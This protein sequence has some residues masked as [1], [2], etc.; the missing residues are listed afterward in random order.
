MG[1]PD[2]FYKDAQG[3]TR[4]RFNKKGG[5]AVAATALAGTVAFGASGI[6]GAGAGG[7]T[8]A[9][10]VAGQ[11]LHTKTESGKSEAR[12]GRSEQAWSRMGWQQL[13]RKIEHA[14]ECAVNSY[15]QVREFF[16]RDPCKSLDRTLL[17][18]ADGNGNTIVVSIAW[19]RMASGTAARKLT[20]LADTDGTGNVSP[21]GAAALGLEG[22]RF[23]G[24]YY[25]SDRRGALAVISEAA[26]ASGHPDGEEMDAATQ[27]AVLLPP[28]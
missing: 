6:G 10:S 2:G 12:K 26:P 7:G 16:V 14:A 19:V 20:D 28:P 18:V 27:I 23:T 1:K 8:A 24:R 3:R 5:V 15:G 9:D 13:R 21:L 4:P 22:I 11:S 25:S 17:A